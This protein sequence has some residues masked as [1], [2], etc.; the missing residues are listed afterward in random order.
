MWV[1]GVCECAQFGNLILKLL[2]KSKIKLKEGSYWEN[3]SEKYVK[4]SQIIIL[5]SD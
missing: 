5:D 2:W 3:C 4:K 1:S